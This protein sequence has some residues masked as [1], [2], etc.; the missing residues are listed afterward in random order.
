VLLGLFRQAEANREIVGVGFDRIFFE[1]GN[2]T[3]Q[4]LFDLTALNSAGAVRMVQAVIGGPAPGQVG[5]GGDNIVWVPD[6]TGTPRRVDIDS[7]ANA[8]TVNETCTPGG[9]DIEVID[10][11]QLIDLDAAFTSPFHV[12]KDVAQ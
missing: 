9:S 1:S 2:C 11:I 8:G 7:S 5:G 6:P 3:G 4:P 10:A 12:Q